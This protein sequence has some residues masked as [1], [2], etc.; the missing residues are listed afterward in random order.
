MCTYT[1]CE[2]VAEWV[3]ARKVYPKV[4]VG[5]VVENCTCLFC[6]IFKWRREFVS[7]YTSV[8]KFVALLLYYY[9]DVVI[10]IILR[11]KISYGLFLLIIIIIIVLYIYYSQITREGRL[12]RR[13]RRN[14]TT[15]FF[16][17]LFVITIINDCRMGMGI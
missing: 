7:T 17:R 13:L 9:N 3:R 2:C 12:C 10:M 14:N 5:R 15:P 16:P 11:H 4:F 6:A 8:R 1:Q